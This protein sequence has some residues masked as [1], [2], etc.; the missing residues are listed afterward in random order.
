VIGVRDELKGESVLVLA[1]LKQSVVPAQQDA[2]AEEIKQMVRQ[3]IGAIATPGAVHFVSMLP[4][5]RSGKVMRRV[6]RAV[7]QGDNLGDLSTIEDDATVDMVREAVETLK[8][9]L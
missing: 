2:V 8:G 6:I 3:R 1:V 7:Y 9:E 4:K 5:T